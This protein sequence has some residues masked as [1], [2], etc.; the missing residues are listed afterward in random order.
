MPNRKIKSIAIV[1]AGNQGPKIAFRCAR[2]NIAAKLYDKSPEAVSRA[3]ENIE[4]WCKNSLNKAETNDVK[5]RIQF[6]NSLVQCVKDVDLAIEA[7]HENVDLKRLIFAEIDQAADARTLICSNSSSL[8]C[9]RFADTTKRQDKI[10]NINFSQPE[11]DTDLLVEVMRGR[12]TSAETMLSAENFVRSL[13]MVP[14]ITYREIMGFSFNRLW[15]GNQKRSSVPGGPGLFGSHDIDRAWMA[16][17][18]T[19]FG[20]FGL[21]DIVGLEVIRDI[22]NQYYQDSGD[23]SDKPPNLL[24]HMIEAGKLGMKSN[25][26]FYSYPNPSYQDPKWLKKEGIYKEDIASKLA[27]IEE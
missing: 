8:P 11:K 12:E 5:G 18:G 14:I 24:D 10:F 19:E 1:G 3:Q 13:R 15:R 23:E 16:Q 9:S 22:E 4:G 20:P 21:M 27:K 6:V 7:V 25:Q 17:F 26:G 2:Y